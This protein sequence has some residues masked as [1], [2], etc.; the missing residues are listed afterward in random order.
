M[1]ELHWFPFFP[2]DWL[3]SPA[4]GMMLPEQRGA[5]IQLLA[6]AWGDGS[7]EPSLPDLESVLANLSGLG[8]RWGKLGFLVREQFE[9]RGGRLYNQKLSDVWNGQQTKHGQAVV[10]G[11]NSAKAR[12]DKRQTVSKQSTSRL[13]QSELES[14]GERAT[15]TTPVANAPAEKAKR[16][17]TPW[18]GRIGAAWKAVYGGDIPRGAATLLSRVVAELGEEETAKRLTAYCE[19]T[20]ANF[21]T[22]GGFAAKHGAYVEQMPVDPRTGTLTAAGLKAWGTGR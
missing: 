6:Y 7:A 3:A 12:A 16:L 13:Q 17:P 14:E 9:A 4:V 8:R 18:M 19:A 21:A 5:F 22:V 15:A 20:P 10:R 11:Q 1:A 2:S